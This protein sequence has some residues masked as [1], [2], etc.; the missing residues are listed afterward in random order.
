MARKGIM[1]QYFEWYMGDLQNNLWIRL[2]D[3]AGHLKE[4]GITSVW[5]PPV[6]KATSPFDSGYGTYDLYDLGE[7]D[8]KGSVRTKYG[9]KEELQEAIRVL[10]D[11]GINVYVDVVLN[12]KAN[13][14]EKETFMARKMDPSNRTRAISES[15]EIEAYTKFTFPGRGDQYSAFKWSWIHF[16]GLDFNARDN[17]RCYLHDRWH[18]QGLVKWRHL[19]KRQF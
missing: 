16:S 8:Q 18:Q 3:D 2:K 14:D 13:G 15:Y 9:S 11:H 5:I 19:R 4:L 10:H 1:F 6:F 17:Q 12:H 7:F